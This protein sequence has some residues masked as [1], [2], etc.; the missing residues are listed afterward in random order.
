VEHVEYRPIVGCLRPPRVAIAYQGRSNWVHSARQAIRSLCRVWGGA[1]ATVLPL[2]DHDA[3]P[4]R[5][6]P[7]L[8][9]Y[10]PDG[11][12]VHAR[13]VADLAVADPGIVD[14]LV[15]QYGFEGETRDAT[16]TRLANEPVHDGPWH[17]A[18]EQV[19]GWCSPF[20]GLQQETR[21]FHRA[22]VNALHRDGQP[23]GGLS[24]LPAEP[25]EPIYTLNLAGVDPFLALA[26]E[27]RVGAL[28]QSPQQG[29]R[30][31]ELPVLDEDLPALVR[32][33]ITGEV[34]R[35]GWD[36]HHRYLTTLGLAVSGE[37]PSALTGESYL[38]GTPFARTLRGLS[39]V[40]T[41]EPPPTVCVIGDTPEDHALGVLCDRVFRHGAWVPMRLLTD[42]G[43]LGRAARLALLH[44]GWL[45]TPDRSVLV[46]S[47]SQPIEVLAELVQELDS[48]LGVEI[49]G[50]PA[51]HEH[52]R[53]VPLEELSGV[54]GRV[55]LADRESFNVRRTVPVRQATGELS[56]LTS[57][58]LPTP[59]ALE[60]LSQDL[61]WCVDVWVP[62]HQPPARTGIPSSA[63]HQYPPGSLPEAVVR[64]SR[65]G[66]SFSSANVGYV[67]AGVPLEGRLAHPLLRLPSAEQ[68]FAQLAAKHGATVQ[69]SSAGR[70]AA[71]A[72]TLWGSF[73]AITTDL[74]GDVRRLLDAFL[75]GAATTGDY[76]GGYAIRGHGYLALGH[77][78]KALGVNDHQARDVLDRLLAFKVLRRGLL[79]NCERC[80]AQAFYPIGA[81]G[82]DGFTCS[83][84]RY[85]SRLARGRWYKRDPEPVWNYD[86]DQVVRE[87]LRQHGDIPLLAAA[88]LAK[89]E[90]SLLWAPELLV[91]SNGEEAEVDLCL[92]IDGRIVIGEAKSNSRL[93]TADKGTA[94]AATRLVR[95]AHIL[96]ADEIMLAT[97]Q[98]SWALPV[99]RSAAQTSR[100]SL[101][102]EPIEADNRAGH[103]HECE[104]PPRVPVPPNLQPPPAAQPRQRP[105]HPPAVA[106]KP[107]RR[108]QPTPGNPRP[109]PT[110]PQPSTIGLAVISLV[111]VDLVGSHPPPPR[112]RAHR[113][114]VVD[115]GRQHG[116][117]SDVGRGDHRGQRQPADL[118]DQVELAPRLATIDGICAHLVPP[119]LVRTL[120]ASTLARD[121]S[122]WS[123]SPSRSKTA[124]CRASNTPAAAHS[125]SRRQQVAGEP[126]PS[127][128]AGSSR[129]GVEVRAM[130]TMAAKQLRAGM[131]RWRP[132]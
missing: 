72:A 63:L 68:I 48:M 32:L 104:P 71:N 24:L 129:H 39:K 61:Q 65:S 87:L 77:A 58:P 86:L 46:V 109:D 117:I 88:H 127:S 56:M 101:G 112:R 12:A 40:G 99:C 111:R 81:V 49:N 30:V 97:A 17:V 132:P 42:D 75:P 78:A 69:R 128:R 98:P 124:R 130:N 51:Q 123:C 36:L 53:A 106:S 1:G 4:Q 45:G 67:P 50:Q 33:A 15:E 52:L 91:E 27:S 114:D 115:H 28:A 5:L 11:V 120:M 74:T 44:L 20:K 23:G 3:I 113:W 7:L 18:A 60:E 19:D 22:Q 25:G 47:A 126:Q 110:T 16:W 121:Q 107:H 8:R 38:A 105:L 93:N 13:T 21:V 85:P 90:Y 89:G 57:V 125:V 31:I 96:S 82:D 122:T 29:L 6:L 55:F 108:L 79:L 35:G 37:P 76:G 54:S 80:S 64:V 73:T 59:A 66:L 70:R 94:R 83:V 62:G 43:Q 102:G 119:R 116:H 2:D 100:H 84:C 10:D 131:A 34:P 92:I 9:S 26:V 41:A 14:R 95:A 103:Q 118:T